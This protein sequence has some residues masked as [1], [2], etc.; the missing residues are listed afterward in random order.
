MRGGPE[1]PARHVRETGLRLLRYVCACV[2]ESV[3]RANARL[4]RQPM[5]LTESTR[6]TDRPTD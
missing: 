5:H 2:K 6:P 4:P 1:Q 3:L